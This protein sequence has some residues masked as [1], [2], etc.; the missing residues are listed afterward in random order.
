MK[1]KYKTRETKLSDQI[2]RHEVLPSALNHHVLSSKRNNPYR[3]RRR[4]SSVMT[5]KS[6]DDPISLHDQSRDS[7]GIGDLRVKS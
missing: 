7:R 6:Q 4:L 1:G 2:N 5:R 3:H